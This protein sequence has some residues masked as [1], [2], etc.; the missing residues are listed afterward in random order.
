MSCCVPTGLIAKFF[1]TV[2]GFLNF[3]QRHVTEPAKLE[4]MDEL[5]EVAGGSA[6]RLLQD[7]LRTV[8]VL[9]PAVLI[10]GAPVP[11]GEKNTC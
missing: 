3:L 7:G 10:G 2:R 8:R 9:L 5:E 1:P 6:F 11:Q 4:K